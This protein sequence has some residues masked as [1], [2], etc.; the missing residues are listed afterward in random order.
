MLGTG[1]GR[2]RSFVLTEKDIQALSRQ[3]RC[4]RCEE[5]KR[6]GSA[7]CN[8]CL[9]LLPE[10]LQMPLEAIDQRDTTVV[11]RGL[12]AAA[13]YFRLRFGSIRDLGGGRRRP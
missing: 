11:I 1:V 9:K 4:P 6:Q 5:A 8:R 10:P 3:E 2:D 7:L 12:R 13:N